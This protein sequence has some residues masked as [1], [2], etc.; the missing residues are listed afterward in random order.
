MDF[1]PL[2]MVTRAALMTTPAGQGMELMRQIEGLTQNVTRDIDS[3][4]EMIGKLVQENDN[5]GVD[6]GQGKC[7]KGKGK[8]GS[9]WL[10]ALVRAMGAIV[11]QQAKNLDQLSKDVAL[12]KDPSA[13]LEFQKAAS[14][15]SLQL[16]TFSSSITQIFQGLNAAAQGAGR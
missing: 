5:F 10:D 15:F 16:N 3:I 9:S 8:G 14:L 12:G 1:K 6:N 13:A 4:Y 7:G 11:D 2:D